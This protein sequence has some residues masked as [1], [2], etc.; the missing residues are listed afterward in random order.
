MSLISSLVSPYPLIKIEG[1]EEC[2]FIE[3]A[4][5]SLVGVIRLL[6]SMQCRVGVN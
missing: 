1:G 5:D 2:V 4:L 3:L 6:I